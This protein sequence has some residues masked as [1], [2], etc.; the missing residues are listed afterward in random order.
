MTP[1]LAAALT[2]LALVLTELVRLRLDT[3]R[4]RTGKKRTRC[5]DRRDPPR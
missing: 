4:R 5:S 1:E 2:G 3:W